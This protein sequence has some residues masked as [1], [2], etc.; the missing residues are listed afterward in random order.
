MQIGTSG[1]NSA[2]AWNDQLWWSADRSSGSGDQRSTVEVTSGR[3][4]IW[5]FGL[6]GHA[7]AHSW[8]LWVDSFVTIEDFLSSTL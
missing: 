3:R 1:P 4:H 5:T 2:G 6:G 8:P 7:E